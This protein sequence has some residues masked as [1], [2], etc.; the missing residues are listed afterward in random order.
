MLT[1]LLRA[2]VAILNPAVCGERQR[3]VF[4]SPWSSRGQRT[5]RMN[6]LAVPLPGISDIGDQNMRSPLSGQPSNL[7]MPRR[8]PALQPPNRPRWYRTR[9]R[10][11]LI[12]VHDKLPESMVTW[13]IRA[14]ESRS[15]RRMLLCASLPLTSERSRPATR[16]G[17]RGPSASPGLCAVTL[18]PVTP[19]RWRTRAS[20][21]PSP[22][23]ERVLVLSA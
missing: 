12:V 10:L 4:A 16:L 17:K 21:R 9:S 22:A 15:G 20:P 5:F 8:I 2:S 13:P 14:G 6:A 19:T 1:A 7:P 3:R 11:S 18:P 23:C